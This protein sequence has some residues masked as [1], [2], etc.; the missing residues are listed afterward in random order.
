MPLIL[1]A[2]TPKT[3]TSALQRR[4][5]ERPEALARAGVWYAPTPP[6]AHRH[7][8]IVRA[9]VRADH[10][11]VEATL[12]DLLATRPAW[13]HTAVISSE[14][15]AMMWSEMREDARADLT[16][17]AAQLQAELWVCFREP[18][19]F[20]ASLYAQFLRNTPVDPMFA[21]DASFADMLDDARFVRRL[22]YAAF[23]RGADAV[24][25][26]AHVRAFR[27]DGAIVERISAA[28]GIDEPGEAVPQDNVSL[29]AA[30][31]DVQRIVNR[32]APAAL[33]PRLAH[34]A[35]QADAIAGAASPPFR[36][37]AAEGARVDA[38]FAADWAALQPRLIA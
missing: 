2:G 20:A 25:G 10:A 28:L 21:R 5:A 29:R 17:A 22:D 19:A 3:G 16:R 33:Q 15:I 23:L 37:S 24:F 7:Q 14:G 6:G 36:L 9:M 35:A 18:K 12:S 8:E 4:F 31:V 26:A 1:H 30:G 32:Y 34:V 13:A 38:L 27:Y 11:G